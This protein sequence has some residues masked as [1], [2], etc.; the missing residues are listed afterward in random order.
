[1]QDFLPPLLG[2]LLG[3][4]VLAALRGFRII[5]DRKRAAPERRGGIWWLNGGL[6]L[7]ALSVAL[8]TLRMR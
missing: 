8:F 1:M 7:V 2:A 5:G 3:A 4:G 6:A